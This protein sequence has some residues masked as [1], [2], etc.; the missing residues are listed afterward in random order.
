MQL[1]KI[2]MKELNNLKYTIPKK[3]MQIQNIKNA[4]LM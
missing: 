1:Q 4:Q 3:K 2:K